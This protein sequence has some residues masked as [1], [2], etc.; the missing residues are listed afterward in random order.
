MSTNTYQTVI[1]LE[2][3]VE[4]KTETKVFCSCR[5]VF[6][7]EPNLNC[8]PGCSG[9]PG[10]LPSL[11][12]RAVEFA[13]RAGL[14]F[15]CE[16]NRFTFFERKHYFYPDLPAGFQV[17]Q[18][19]RPL[20]VGGYVD[21]GDKRIR[22]NRIH[23]EEDAGKL[24]H[25]N[26]GTLVDCNRGCM[27]LIEIVTEP[28]LR[29]ADEALAFLEALKSIVK[30]TGVSDAKMEQG[31]LRCDVNISVNR[32]GEKLGVRTEMKNIAS[33]KAV[34]RAILYESK[35]HR[36]VIEAG[37]KIVQE[38]RRWDDAKGKSFS[39]RVKETAADYRYFPAPDIPPVRIS[40][41]FIE[42]VRKTLPVLAAGRAKKYTGD[43]GL[44]ATAAEVLTSDKAIADFFDGC[45]AA[46]AKPKSAA[47]WV[48]TEILRKVK[49]SED[50]EI[51]IR[52]ADL[53]AVIKLL[54]ENAINQ[55]AARALFEAYWKGDSRAPEELIKALGL[56]QMSDNSALE[57]IIKG[58]IDASP[59]AVKDYRAGNTKAFAYFVGQ[60]MKAT[61]GAASPAAVNEIV[62]T[63]LG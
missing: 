56:E 8:C 43:Y 16:I 20:C 4:L 6:N 48:M 18:L 33:F 28:D 13:V 11:N 61:K 40:E 39:M 34:N 51:T 35:R 44:P 25:S 60:A 63:L 1:G 62:K 53:A 37:G 49:E 54:D 3:H 12:A 30:Y 29:S 22:L 26:A 32:P 21:I 59:A 38:T 55:N 7:P 5:T 42:S 58:I 10:T 45:V 52:P 2:V 27:P 19:A 17:S 24:V 14:A 31:S 50:I 47:N 41:E 23:L 57:G 15:N 46:G 36:D 9:M